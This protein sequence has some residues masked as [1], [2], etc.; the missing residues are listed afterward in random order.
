M[1]KT[2]LALLFFPAIAL[3]DS[4]SVV[5]FLSAEY[6]EASNGSDNSVAGYGYEAVISGKLSLSLDYTDARYEDDTV[7]DST[8]ANVNFAIGSFDE[9]SYYVGVGA[10]IPYNNDSGSEFTKSKKSIHDDLS[11]AVN[12]GYS[13]RSGKGLDYNIGAALVDDRAPIY[14]ASMLVPV[15]T[16]GFGLSLGLKKSEGG[17][18]YTSVGV[19]LTL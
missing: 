5:N 10:V 13:K 12:V 7:F 9:G 3:A 14:S 6:A 2:L 15:G 11:T 18:T 19:S 4:S 8:N 1:K 17:F 16:S